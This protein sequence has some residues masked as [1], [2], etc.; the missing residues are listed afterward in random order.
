MYN[1]VVAIFVCEVE[2]HTIL[3]ST[4]YVNMKYD[5]N[6][7]HLNFADGE[8]RINNATNRRGMCILK[9]NTYIFVFVYFF[10]L[11]G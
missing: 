7:N 6:S 8:L 10:T 3:Q 11:N 9:D 4:L 5:R 2:Y 1:F